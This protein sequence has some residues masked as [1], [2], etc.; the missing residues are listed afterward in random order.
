MNKGRFFIGFTAAALYAGSLVFPLS[1]F[2]GTITTISGL[3]T[4]NGSPVSG[5]HV[6]AV[7]DKNGVGSSSGSGQTNTSGI[8]T[9]TFPES[10]C[11]N[12]VDVYVNASKD[13]LAGSNSGTVGVDQGIKS[14]YIPVELTQKPVSV[15][16]FGFIPGIIATVSSTGAFLALKKR[17]K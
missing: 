6:T 2:A 5:A 13:D 9:I 16:E 8:Y 1:A 3:V 4:Y 15:P 14:A 12:K 7:C 11:S 17:S 10:E